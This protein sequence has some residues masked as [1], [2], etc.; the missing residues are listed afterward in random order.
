M[1]IDKLR[2][3][4]HACSHVFYPGK[5][6]IKSTEQDMYGIDKNAKL[7]LCCS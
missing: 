1:V 7:N 3:L 6:L 2:M 5:C 4:P